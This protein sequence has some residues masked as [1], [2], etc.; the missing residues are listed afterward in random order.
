MCV[1]VCVLAQQT[2]LPI[3][4]LPC[5][6]WVQREEVR[7][8]AVVRH[9]SVHT[10][11]GGPRTPV[12]L[13]N[14]LSD[15]SQ[16]ELRYLP[17]VCVCVRLGVCV[18]VCASFFASTTPLILTRSTMDSR[19]YYMYVNLCLGLILVTNWGLSWPGRSWLFCLNNA[20]TWSVPTHWYAPRACVRV[21][22]RE[23]G[24][25]NTLRHTQVD[26]YRER[27]R[28]DCRPAIG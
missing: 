16:P 2:P 4:V 14:L 10:H 9:N 5:T 1:C 7:V 20:Y 24:A 15:L 26:V 25:R 11:D 3:Q 23:V 12:W 13:T 18:C 8:F 19:K 21:C 6:R 28:E 22:V 17:R 27:E